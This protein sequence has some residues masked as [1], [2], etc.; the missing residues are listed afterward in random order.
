MKKTL[1]FSLSLLFLLSVK[2]TLQVS[3]GRR[4]AVH[5]GQGGEVDN[6]EVNVS[7]SGGDEV[8]WSS[9][10]GEFTISFP[11]SPFAASSF[12]VPAGGSA[13]SGA[14]RPGAGYG[15]YQYFITDNTTGQSADPG[16]NIKP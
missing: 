1:L 8:V 12:H 16:V 6:E 9:D 13:N 14:L 10:G 15:H 7:E 5:I 4:L 11:T 2:P 3:A